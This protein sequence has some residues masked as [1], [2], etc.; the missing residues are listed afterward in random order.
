MGRESQGYAGGTSDEGVSYFKKLTAFLFFLN[1]NLF[2]LIG[3]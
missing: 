3:G 2:I 1:T